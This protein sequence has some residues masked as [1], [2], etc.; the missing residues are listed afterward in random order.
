MEN[1]HTLYL[2]LSIDFHL[3]YINDLKNKL[4]MTAS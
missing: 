4:I 1:Q 3:H 2:A